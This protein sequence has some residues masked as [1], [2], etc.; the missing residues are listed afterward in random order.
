MKRFDKLNYY[1]L[2]EIPFDACPFRVR[3]AYRS[4]RD[5]YVEGSLLTYSLFTADEREEILERIK[6]AYATLID[7]NKRTHYNTTLEENGEKLP[8]V[9][10]EDE[11]EKLIPMPRL[12]AYGSSSSDVRKAKNKLEEQGVRELLNSMMS[13]KS[14]S[15]YDLK[16]LREAL[17]VEFDEVVNVTKISPIILQAIE[18]DEFAKLPPRVYL[19]SFL[20][21]Y[22]EVLETDPQKVIDGYFKNIHEYTE[23]SVN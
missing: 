11:T 4:V 16:E 15:G 7:T 3:E 21:A 10:Q 22:A 19:R 18:H 8:D 6:R 23:R 12:S 5:T 14:I 2:F 13:A 17:G 20:S 1:E 9:E